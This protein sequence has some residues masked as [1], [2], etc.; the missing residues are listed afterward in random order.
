[1]YVSCRFSFS[2]KNYA[3]SCHSASTAVIVRMA[4]VLDFRS[5]EFLRDTV[6][7]AIWSDTE[8]GLAI[9]AGSMATLRPLYRVI[10]SRLGWTLSSTTPISDNKG[11]A[12][13]ARSGLNS[14]NARRK[15]SGPFSLIT[16]TRND[17]TASEEEYNLEGCKPVKLRDDLVGDRDS[18]GR[19]VSE[20]GFKSW[21]IQVGSGSEEELNNEGITRQ[22]DVYMSSELDSRTKK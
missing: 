5:P 3:D 13:Y 21:R 22:T 6:D 9:T 20:K 18:K 15:K 12:P 11:S 4:F 16:M 17:G 2:V 14:G 19:P 7:I 8:Q 1:M 10:T